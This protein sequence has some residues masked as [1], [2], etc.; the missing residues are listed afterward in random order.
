VDFGS[1]GTRY[2]NNRYSKTFV[3]WSY[4]FVRTEHQVAYERLFT[5]VKRVSR[6]FFGIDLVLA[7]GSLD[8]TA[9]IANAFREVWP[10]IHLL[11]CWPHFARKARE[12]VGAELY[13]ALVLPHIRNL[14]E[15]RSVEQFAAHAARLGA[16]WI[17][18][19]AGDFAAWMK[20]YYLAEPWGSWFIA[21][22]GVA[23][24]V[25]SQNPIESHHRAIKA[26]CVSSLRAST[27]VVLNDS[28]P[29]VL[30][31][32][33]LRSACSFGHFAEGEYLD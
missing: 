16:F 17:D 12:R 3:P 28:I 30:R 10:E 8:H 11:N 21:S 19:G 7:F 33:A 2:T 14:H 1:Y 20:E 26:V 22:S 9:F 15:S 24:I 32:E 13:E 23:G 29:G 25:S 18:Q 27:A 4:M 6:D 5:V 31:L